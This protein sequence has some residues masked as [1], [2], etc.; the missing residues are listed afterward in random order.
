[1]SVGSQK[2]FNDPDFILVRGQ[3]LYFQ[4]QE[5]VDYLIYENI[6]NVPNYW[7]SVYP[8]SDRMIL[9]GI[10]EWNE[11]DPRNTAEVL[12]NILKNAQRCFSQDS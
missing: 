3:L 11:E 2:L 12:E 5:G 1:M 4:R 7:V 9:G 6:P 8:W 10:Y